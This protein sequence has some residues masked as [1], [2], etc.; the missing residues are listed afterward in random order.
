MPIEITVTI[1][2][3]VYDVLYANSKCR[4]SKGDAVADACDLLQA[5]GQMELEIE[6]E[7]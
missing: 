1:V 5:A 2:D 7:A 3:D 6:E 4:L